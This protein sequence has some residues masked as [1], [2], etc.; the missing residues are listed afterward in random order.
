MRNFFCVFLFLFT[1]LNLTHAGETVVVGYVRSKIDK[2]PI[3]GVNVYLDGTQVGTQTDEEGFYVLRHTG[4][5][6]KVV[7]SSIGYTTRV[8]T[9]RAG[10]AVSITVELRE[11]IRA[12]QELLVFPGVNPAT[13]LMKKVRE[14]AAAN[15]IHNVDQPLLSEEEELVMMPVGRESSR[16]RFDRWTAGLVSE[17]DSS[18]FL[19]LY[20]SSVKSHHQGRNIR[21]ILN[22][23]ASAS[24]ENLMI[25]MEKLTGSLRTEVNFYN[26]NLV[27]FGKNIISP[28]SSAGNSFYRYFLVDSIVSSTGKQYFVRFW[29]KN[30]KNLAFNGEMYIDSASLALTAITVHLPRQAN[31]N[32]IN[33]LSI[34][35]QFVEKGRLWVPFSARLKMG[36]SYAVPLD[37]NSVVPEIYFYKQISTVLSDSVLTMQQ[38]FAGSSFQKE[39]LEYKL[40]ELNDLSIM[41]TARWVADIVITGYAQLGKLDLGKVYQLARLTEQEGLRISV[42]F[43][44]NELLSPYFTV[45]GYW[46]YAMGSEKHY[47]SA[48]TGL[49]LPFKHKTVL[50]FG[51]TD[52][53]RRTDYEYNDY[54]VK[55]NA[56]LSGDMDIAN[57]LISFTSANQLNRRTEW[58]A[59]LT[60][61][62][63]DNVESGFYFRSNRYFSNSKLPFISNNSIDPD[64]LHQ[65]LTF[66][67]RFSSGER[68]YED[69]LDRIYIQNERPV[70]YVIAEAGLTRPINETLSYARL[71]LKYKQKV[72]FST[73]QWMYSVDAGWLFGDV[74]YNLYFNQGSGKAV[75]HRRLHF[76]LMGYMEYSYDKYISTH[77]ELQ[78]NGVLFNSIP[79]LKN[80]NWRELLTFKAIYGGMDSRRREVY[81]LPET[82]SVSQKP[83]F[84]IGAGITNI[85]KVASLQSVWRLTDRA[86][87]GVSP[88]GIVGGI[89]FNF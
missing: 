38:G 21:H 14:A 70:L 22:K 51:F 52:D 58:N 41:K 43:R 60:R 26:N 17:K 19:P 87:S 11:D 32:Y 80:F 61:D 45:G 18:E 59:S 66:V 44:T 27:M 20:M 86:K 82:L 7:F 2:S 25:L 12:L 84:E 33:A 29:S 37:S 9:I 35:Q 31:L 36:M 78:F 48:Y 16:R 42:P 74:P 88:W 54:M 79:V 8:V 5:E 4:N 83:Y 23:S 77:H 40:A 3:P 47:F 65:S 6:N 75:L 30:P 46:G 49:K 85:F 64:Y 73:G 39:E 62:W 69:H 76:N 67:T 81:S 68:T 15:D 56:L 57:T 24:P 63:N 28:L 1:F 71:M 53:L 13:L 50:R 72:L 89:R 55:E 34:E 10:E